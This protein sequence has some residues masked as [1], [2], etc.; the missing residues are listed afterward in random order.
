MTTKMVLSELVIRNSNNLN[1][2]VITIIKEWNYKDSGI[3]DVVILRFESEK[4]RK[5]ATEIVNDLC[6]KMPY[7]NPIMSP[8]T[9]RKTTPKTNIR[10][11]SFIIILFDAGSVVSC[12]L[13][14][15]TSSQNIKT[16]IFLF[17]S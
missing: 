14:F 16:F 9:F 2:Y 6:N 10:V 3:H 5:N 11:G 17:Y 1:S 15:I 7:E 4:Y 12:I 8:P 13:F